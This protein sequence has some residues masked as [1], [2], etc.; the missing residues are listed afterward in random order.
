MIGELYNHTVVLAATCII[1]DFI[2][3]AK[4]GDFT[5]L[6]VRSPKEFNQ[7]HI[8]GAHN[9]PLLNDDERHIVGITYKEQGQNAAV[10]K[11][12][13]LVGHKFSTY[14]T[15]AS[16]L[17]PSGKILIYCWRGGLRS[18][19]MAWLLG[20]SG[21]DVTLLKGGYKSYRQWCQEQF[22]AERNLLV[23]S[24]K[25]GTGKSD[26]LHLLQTQN[27]NNVLDLE[28]L[29]DHKGSAFGGLGQAT[30]S[31]QEQFE[32][33]LGWRLEELS[34]QLIWVEDE[35]RLIGRL[36]IPDSFFSRMQ[37]SPIVEVE[38]GKAARSELILK[39]YGKFPKAL[40]EEKTQTLKKRMGGDRVKIAL[41]CL[42]SGDM[43]GW[44]DP[45]LDYYDRAYAHGLSLKSK[46][47]IATIDADKYDEGSLLK[48]LTEI[49]NVPL[50]K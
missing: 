1:R 35:S 10:K 21:V 9:L 3:K 6:D 26:L 30:Q 29:A 19:V 48:H 47:V 12:F 28:M 20:L 24:G 36:R 27:N 17:S 32:N 14:I 15:E 31:T 42:E 4:S 18:N 8:H 34:A 22:I 38:R 33:D 43:Q 50:K 13:E 39:D 11:G 5:V 49:S 40:L 7:G 37:R 46:Q 25:T 16:A 23:L 44:L 41:T 2:S 45:L